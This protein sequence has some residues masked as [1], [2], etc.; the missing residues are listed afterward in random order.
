MVI[1]RYILLKKKVKPLH[2]SKKKGTKP[3]AKILT[4]GVNSEENSIAPS[5][6]V[7]PVVTDAKCHTF[8]PSDNTNVED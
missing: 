5:Q 2:D 7:V 6:G 1:L 3:Y 4:E 8:P